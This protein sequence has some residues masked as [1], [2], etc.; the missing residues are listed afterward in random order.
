MTPPKIY[1]LIGYPVKHSLSPA[2]HNAAFNY[3]KRNG[4]INYDAE[5]RLFEVI[6]DRLEGFLLNSNEIFKDTNNNSIRAADVLGFNIT[7][8]HKVRAKEILEKKFP[9]PDNFYV[10]VS[11]AVN[12]VK[13]NGDKLDYDNTDASG[14][15]AALKRDLKFDPKGKNVLIIGCGGAGRAIIAALS[16]MLGI[17]NIYINDISSEAMDSAEKHFKQIP[18]LDRHTKLKFIGY[19][20]MPSIIRG[21]HLLVNATP[22]GMKENDGSVIDKDL[23]YKGLYVYDVV[24]NRQTQLIKDAREKGCIAKE[25]LGMLLYQGVRSFEIFTGKTAP[26][27]IMRQALNETVNKL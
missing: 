12:T 22:M 13:R 24:Y 21:C 7:I 3:L 5:Y 14:F 17:I 1:G 20:E 4:E 8:P 9:F 23:L 15:R 10:N 26:I 25:G 6:P 11:G 27:E 16:Y 19:K 2:M 18:A